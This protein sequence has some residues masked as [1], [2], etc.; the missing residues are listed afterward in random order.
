MAT[1]STRPSGLSSQ[2]SPLRAEAVSAEAAAAAPGASC[3]SILSDL[4][5][6]ASSPATV[7]TSGAVCFCLFSFCDP[8]GR[9]RSLD[10]AG[11]SRSPVAVSWPLCVARLVCFS[12]G[13]LVTGRETTG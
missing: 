6:A 10:G 3:V 13:R 1:T 2:R 9:R 8:A 5:G 4:G 7:P 11:G 12:F